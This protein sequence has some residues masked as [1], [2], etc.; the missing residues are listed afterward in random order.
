MSYSPMTPGVAPS[1][2]NPQTPGAGM[3]SLNFTDWFTTDIEVRVK[4]SHNDAGL[5]GQVRKHSLCLLK[6]TLDTL[7]IIGRINLSYI[8]Y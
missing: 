7:C 8:L 1:P 4:D 2:L 5:G 6:F 3:D